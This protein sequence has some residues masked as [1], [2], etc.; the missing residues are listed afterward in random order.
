ME[1]AAVMIQSRFRGFAVRRDIGQGPRVHREQPEALGEEDSVVIEEP[2]DVAKP[3]TD[4]LAAAGTPHEPEEEQEEE[5][6]TTIGGA[7]VMRIP[8]QHDSA[9]S[10][11]ATFVVSSPAPRDSVPP[12]LSLG[13]IR[14]RCLSAGAR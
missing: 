4:E 5:A 7:E 1:Q 12:R 2:E 6:V 3:E 14:P 9:A 13:W 10:T 8:A 11:A